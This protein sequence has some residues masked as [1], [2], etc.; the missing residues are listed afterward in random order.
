LIAEEGATHG[1]DRLFQDLTG[2]RFVLVRIHGVW[3]L[4]GESRSDQ[5]S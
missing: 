2:F 1:I 4:L 3:I 5:N